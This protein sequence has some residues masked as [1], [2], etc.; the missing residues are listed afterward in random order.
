MVLLNC[1]SCILYL[2]VLNT[3]IC[4]LFLFYFN[5]LLF[6]TFHKFQIHKWFWFWFL[7]L[8]F[9]E[10][11]PN[12]VLCEIRCLVPHT[13]KVLKGFF[14]RLCG[15]MKNHHLLENHFGNGALKNQIVRVLWDTFIG[16][17][18]NSLRKWFF[19]EPWFKRLFV[20]PDMGP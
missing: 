19:R 5:S 16:S 15:S 20:E 3:V 14:K 7:D 4:L 6:C 8:T 13:I 1:Y 12:R 11:E 17:M 10:S 18:K 9:K 2:L